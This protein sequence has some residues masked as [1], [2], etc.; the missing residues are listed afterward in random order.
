[1]LGLAREGVLRQWVSIGLG[2]SDED[3]ALFLEPTYSDLC[4]DTN[5]RNAQIHRT[6]AIKASHVSGAPRP[7]HPV[8][9][10]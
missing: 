1:M 9:M 3:L 4:L 7:L 6:N 2:V 5:Q 10:S 8:E